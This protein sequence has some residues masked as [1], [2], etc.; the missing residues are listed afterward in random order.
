MIM[1]DR[2]R[3]PEDRAQANDFKDGAFLGQSIAYGNIVVTERR[4]AHHANRT[5]VAKQ[6][7]TT[8]LASLKDL[9]AVLTKEGCL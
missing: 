8:V 3:S 5:G 2:D 9:P 1:Y 6:Y 7:D 4:W